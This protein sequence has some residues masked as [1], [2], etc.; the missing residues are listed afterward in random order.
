MIA[1]PMNLSS[2]P[3]RLLDPLHHQREVLVQQADGALRAELSVIVVKLRMSENRIVAI[4]LLPPRMSSC[5]PEPMSWSA[6]PGI[7][8]ARHRRLHALLGR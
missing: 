7:H 2:M 4:A 3:P 1:S 5:R 8:V 6:M